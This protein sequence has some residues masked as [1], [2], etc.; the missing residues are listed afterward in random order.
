MALFVIFV[1]GRSQVRLQFY[2]DVLRR[3][4]DLLSRWFSYYHQYNH[5]FHKSQGMRV[6]KCKTVCLVASLSSDGIYVI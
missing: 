4:A 5:G 3:W 2:N 1:D 6:H